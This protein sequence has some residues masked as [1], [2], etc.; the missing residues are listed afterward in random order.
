MA[1]YSQIRHSSSQHRF[2]IGQNGM[3]YFFCPN[4]MGHDKQFSVLGDGPFDEASI[5][6]FLKA[7]VIHMH[8]VNT[9][10]FGCG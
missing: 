1:V 4:A 5:G 7:R 10:A 9:Q 6:H 2:P 8:G 3:R